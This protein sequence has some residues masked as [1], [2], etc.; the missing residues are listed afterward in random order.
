M[1]IPEKT[2]DEITSKLDILDYISQDVQLVRK[3]DRF[4][5]CC[6]FHK[7]K[8]PSFSVVPE[9][10]FY[11]CFGCHKGGNIYSYIME[12]A[13]VEFLDAVKIAAEKAGIPLEFSGSSGK[14]ERL[15]KEALLE[16][17]KKV[18][19]S[20]HWILKNSPEA[21]PAR[22]YLEERAVELESWDF[23]QLGYAPADPHWL[24][25]F[26]VSK[27]YTPEFLEKSGLFSRNRK[28]FPLFW[29]RLMFPIFDH[30]GRPVAF[31]GRILQ[32]D[33]PKYINSPETNIYH[34]GD[35]LFGLGKTIPFI[36]ETKN[37]FLCEGNL[38]VIA[39]YQ[40]G[41]KQVAA[42]LG[43][44]FT[45]GQLKILKRYCKNGT[46]VFDSDRAGK[47][48]SYKAALLC[49]QENLPVS[50]VS[51]PEGKDPADIFKASGSEELKKIVNNP[52]K[53][54]DFLLL[55]SAEGIDTTIPEGKIEV[56]EKLAPFLQSV[57]S[58][59]EKSEYLEKI[60]D[61]L[62]LDKNIVIKELEGKKGIKRRIIQNKSESSFEKLELNDEFFLVLLLLLNSDL[63]PMIKEIDKEDIKSPLVVE[64]IRQ[65]ENKGQIPRRE[66]WELLCDHEGW[67]DLL[68]QKERDPLFRI[69]A[70]EQFLDVVQKI[71]YKS[72]IRKRDEISI[73]MRK[74]ENQSNERA[75]WELM[76]EKKRLD[77]QIER[78]KV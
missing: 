34:K 75:I 29:R 39:M 48:A 73:L 5:G 25:N 3:G 32:G 42:P 44:A 63:Y 9:K 23:F 14:E 74:E 28:K 15:D 17:Y 60:A 64:T 47:E 71:R 56:I 21:Q 2:I 72:L 54:F 45:P 55:Y 19:G 62:I 76:Q 69:N 40:A 13:H 41:L 27:N 53:S 8:S 58:E 65:L 7:E 50:I 52:V 12:T 70:R 33:G 49:K 11:Y 57:N 6:P 24:Y 36:K 31:S 46:I 4:W 26:L 20:F 66:E 67:A 16:L 1:R 78:L 18:T 59:I 68:Q 61:H 43:T 77:E 22:Q 30:S 35:L 37:F 38:D 51:L 10:G